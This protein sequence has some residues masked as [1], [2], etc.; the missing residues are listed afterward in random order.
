MLGLTTPVEELDKELGGGQR[1]PV[2]LGQRRQTSRRLGDEISIADLPGPVEHPLPQRIGQEL[3]CGLLGQLG[4]AEQR[5][6]RLV[7]IVA[8]R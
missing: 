7:R 4:Q 6:R 8:E 5:V 1:I 3:V 2:T